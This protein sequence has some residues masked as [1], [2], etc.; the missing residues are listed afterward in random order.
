[1]SRE[2]CSVDSERNTERREHFQMQDI[3]KD[4]ADGRSERGRLS[5]A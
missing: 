3:L 5:F 4:R 2:H 1:M